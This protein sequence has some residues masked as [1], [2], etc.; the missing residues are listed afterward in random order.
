DESWCLQRSQAW[1]DG[2]RVLVVEGGQEALEIARAPLGADQR[3]EVGLDIRVGETIGMFV[4]RA[5]RLRRSIDVFVRQHRL[6]SSA[7]TASRRYVQKRLEGFGRPIVVGVAVGEHETAYARGVRRREDLR[8]A[9]AAV[10]ADE[11]DFVDAQ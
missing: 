7:Q 1:F 10:V 3:P 9:A 11:I 4:G 2:K 8:N 5:E 6:E